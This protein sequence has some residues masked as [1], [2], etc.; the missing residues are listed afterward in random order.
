[1]LANPTRRAILRTMLA[2]G[3]RSTSP[4][5]L[6]ESF[7]VRLPVL[8]YH[9]RTMA[10]NNALSLDHASDGRGSLQSFYVP[11]ALVK[12][13]PEFVTEELAADG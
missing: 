10:E 7:G 8:A 12:A 6:S 4:T 13:S 5:T 1:M 11:G 9:V 2:E 3:A